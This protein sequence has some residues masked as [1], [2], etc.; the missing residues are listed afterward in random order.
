MVYIVCGIAALGGLLFGLDQG[1]IANSLFAIRDVYGLTIN[2]GA[3]YAAVLAFTLC[4]AGIGF[5]VGIASFVVPL[6][7]IRNGTC[8]NSWFQGHIVSNDDY[9]W[10]ICC[11][12]S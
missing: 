2:Q 6:L 12:Y 5:A 9:G 4:R 7:F 10:D 8:Q 1:F 3:H 11:C